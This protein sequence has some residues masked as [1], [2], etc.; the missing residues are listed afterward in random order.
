MK[1][2]FHPAAAIFPLITG[3]EFEKLVKDIGK[4]G[5]INEIWLHPDGSILDGRNRYR[6]CLE[7]GVEPR[8]KM[9]DGEG[10]AADFVWSLNDQRRHLDGNQRK[11]AAARYAIELEREGK[12]RQGK[13]T[14][15]TLASNEAD[16]AFGKSAEHAAEKFNE[17]RAT[18]ER[19]VK[20]V[21]EGSD[22]LLQAVERGDVSVSAAADVAT[23]SKPQ[24]TE[25]VARGEDA[26]IKEAARIRRVRKEEKKAEREAIKRA[27]PDDLPRIS[28]RYRLIH[29]DLREADIKPESVDCIITDPPYPEEF[30]DCFKW[31]ADC[32]S[33]WLKTGGTLA[34]MSGQA[35]LPQVIANLCSNPELSY[36]WTMA[37]LTPGG[38]AVQVFPRKVNTF[39]KPI[40]LMTKGNGGDWIGDVCKSDVNNNDKRFH[41]WGQ[42]ESGMADLIERISIPGQVVCDPFLGGGTTGVV[43][44]QMNRI[45]VGCDIDENNIKISA[46]RM[47]EIKDAA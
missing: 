3:E 30:L 5:L 29:S 38:Q 41:H 34:V 26:I 42:S 44:V 40:I 36:R 16:V 10:F 24:Q 39:W 35:H 45:F 7:A 20:V 33:T 31:L 46:S 25:I 19:A 6:A 22:E 37:Y 23:L 2:Q 14:D 8:F 43:A 32:A 18:V 11:L 4:I 28:M 15:L 27:V 47:Q 9:W 12:E 1:L 13:R 17:S 21:K